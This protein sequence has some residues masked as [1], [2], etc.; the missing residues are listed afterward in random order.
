[1]S[2]SIERLRE[3]VKDLEYMKDSKYNDEYLYFKARL[4]NEEEKLKE[5]FYKK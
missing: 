5:G 3:V 2:M 4:E 1:M